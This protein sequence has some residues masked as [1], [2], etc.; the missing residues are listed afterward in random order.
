[1]GNIEVEDQVRMRNLTREDR[2]G[3]IEVRYT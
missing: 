1:M 2:I 3:E